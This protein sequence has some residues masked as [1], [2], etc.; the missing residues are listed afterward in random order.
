[1]YWNIN[2]PL[3]YNALY[4]FIVGNRGSGKSYGT[5]EFCIKR[6]LKNKEQFVYVRRFKTELKKLNTFFNDIHEA[7]DGVK[8][9]VKGKTFW[10]NDELAGYAIALSTA[11][12]EK[13]NAYPQV[14][15]IMFDEFI[16][17]RGFHKYIPDEVTSFLEL[18]ETIARMREGVRVIFLANAISWT[19]P[20]FLYFNVQPP[21]KGKTIWCKN[22]LL[23]QLVADSEFIANKKKT[24]FAKVIAGTEYANY[25]ID[26]IMLRDSNTFVTAAPKTG[27]YL[28]TI[29]SGGKFYGVWFAI[30][31][32]ILFISEKFDPSC[33]LIY[34]TIMDDHTPNTMLLKSIAKSENMK[35]LEKSFKRG[36]VY[37]DSI[38]TKNIIMET[39]KY[40]GG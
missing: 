16:L 17:D 34:V 19:N 25:S 4:N 2:E 22:D 27:K 35:T 5:K 31:C 9:D 10:I 23:V 8:F 36:L 39:L 29:K 30:D 11:K 15:T 13:S 40:L 32:S 21:V 12:V 28:F 1:M 6:F 38:K 18:Y 14:K 33:K 37:F 7:F 20:Y 3:T 24:R 26:N